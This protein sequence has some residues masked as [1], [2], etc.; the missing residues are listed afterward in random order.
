MADSDYPGGPYSTCR[1]CGE[2]FIGGPGCYAGAC[3]FPADDETRFTLAQL[4][5]VAAE[6]AD[7]LASAGLS[8]APHLR[9]ILALAEEVG[10]F[11]GASRRYYGMARRNGPRS[12]VEAELADVVITAF[13]TAHTM[14]IDLEKA[15]AAKLQV[16]FTRGWRQ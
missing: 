13:V 14:D 12:D 8:A 6:A 9:Q 1:E 11:V 4:P 3:A 10:E 16:V 15:I 5:A 2:P 7:Q